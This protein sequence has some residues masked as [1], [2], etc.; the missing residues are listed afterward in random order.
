V[1]GGVALK[2][3]S[4]D[5]PDT[6]RQRT[7]Q[8]ASDQASYFMVQ[9]ELRVQPDFFLPR[10][11]LYPICEGLMG[12]TMKVKQLWYYLLDSGFTGIRVCDILGE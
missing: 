3:E 4:S 1:D 11:D 7:Q 6:T 10:L 12:Q 2:G 8:Q 9:V 5:D